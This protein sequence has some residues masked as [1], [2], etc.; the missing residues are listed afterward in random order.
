MESAHSKSMSSSCVIWEYA[1]AGHVPKAA[2]TT[3]HSERKGRK[4]EIGRLP[5]LVWGEM[6]GW[7][8]AF[9]A[10]DLCVIGLNSIALDQTSCLAAPAVRVWGIASISKSVAKSIQPLPD[11][12]SSA[13]LFEGGH[14]PT[15][16]E[17]LP[18]TGPFSTAARSMTRR[19]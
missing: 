2:R 19:K 10:S 5:S 17:R 15:D 9:R 18:A 7:Q 11:C 12:Y 8:Q 16:R 3:M 1:C 4:E 6:T 14:R 13:T